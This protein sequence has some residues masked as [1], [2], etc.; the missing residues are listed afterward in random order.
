MKQNKIFLIEGKVMF[1]FKGKD[2]FDVMRKFDEFCVV[3]RIVLMEPF[4]I[5]S[6]DEIKNSS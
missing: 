3:N 1:G 5:K 2:K 4:T 6:E